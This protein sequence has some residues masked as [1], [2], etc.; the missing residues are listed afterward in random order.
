MDPSKPLTKSHIKTCS[1]AIRL[2]ISKSQR[3]YFKYEKHLI[4]FEINYKKYAPLY[5]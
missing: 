1:G 5:A 4:N 3:H 2:K